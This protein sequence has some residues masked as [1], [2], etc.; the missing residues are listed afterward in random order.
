MFEQ[1]LPERFTK[2]KSWLWGQFESARGGMLRFGTLSLH[3]T[4]LAHIVYV[5]GLSEFAEKKF[6]LA[7]DFNKMS[8]NFSVFDRYGQGKSPR[9]LADPHKQ[10]SDGVEQDIDD[11]ITYCRTHIPA[12][13]PIVLLGHSTGGLLALM[14]QEREPDL[15][16]ATILT[17]P[18]L[19][20]KNPLLY[21]K[22]CFYAKAPFP[23]WLLEKYSPG[24]K[25]WEVRYDADGRIDAESFSADPERRAVHDYWAHKDPELQAGSPTMGWVQKMCRGIIKARNPAFLS[26]INNPMLVFTVGREDLINNKH[27]V[28]AV[29]HLANG[30]HHHLPQSHHEP[31][32]ETNDIRDGVLTQV[33]HFLKNNL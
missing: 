7:R 31:L 14:A 9:Y 32:M 4:P 19:G 3:K 12:G 8:C 29:T 10:H 24:G 21:N 23:N 22:E 16:K 26:R 17:A 28:T 2:P 1:G 33:Q 11:I 13:E 18:L 15:I 30:E 5:E 25:P 27:T 6:E 20:F